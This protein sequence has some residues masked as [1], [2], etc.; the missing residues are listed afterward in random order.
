M[1]KENL[2]PAPYNDNALSRPN[3]SAA[4]LARDWYSDVPRSTFRHTLLGF[5]LM[6]GAFGGFGYWAIAAPLAA[7]VIVQGS[8]VATGQNKIIQHLEGGIIREIL[9]SEGDHVVEGQP[10]IRLDETTALAN[11]RQLALRRARLEAIAARLNAES[12]Q[13]EEI[14]FTDFLRKQEQDSE[15]RSILES[16]RANFK[17]SR[18]KLQ[19]DLRLLESNIESLH[20]RATGYEAQSKAISRQK[21][22]LNEDLSA[23]LELFNIGLV[24]K[25]EVNRIKR[26]LVDFDGEIARLDSQVAETNSQASKLLQQKTQT[27]EAYRQAALDEM[28]AIEAELD[29]VRE[30]SRSAENILR[31]AILTAP[32]SGTIIKL[33]YH[34]AGGVVESGKAILEILPTGVPLIIETQVLR[35][36]IDTVR[37]GQPATIRLTALNQRITPVLM[38]EVIYVSADSLPDVDERGSEREVYVARMSLEASEMKRVNGFS[39]TPGMPAE[40]MIQTASRTFAD[41]ITRPITDSMSRAFREQ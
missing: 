16:Q 24:H 40:V 7:A 21:S 4:T 6:L 10:L 35:T 32:S 20:L 8:F 33:N 9:V 26:A 15:V 36:D 2:T 25:S 17:G 1:S 31:R 19:S 13:E 29:S 5:V 34:T 38:G 28:Q 3:D 11:E 27:I 39:P 41:Y 12:A 18:R 30:Q 14:I 37:V 22:L 23:R